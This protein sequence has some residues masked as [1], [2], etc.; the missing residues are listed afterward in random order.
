M[1]YLY[2][3]LLDSIWPTDMFW[4]IQ[5]LRCGTFPKYLDFGAAFQKTEG[6]KSSGHA[7]LNDSHKM[8]LST[9]ANCPQQTSTSSSGGHGPFSPPWLHS[10]YLV[11]IPC[12]ASLLQASGSVP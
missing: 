9:V 6:S 10:Y 4:P 3:G 7:A 1:D 11:C 8:E 2:W 12:L 5:F